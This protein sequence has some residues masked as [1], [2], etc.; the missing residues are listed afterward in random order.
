MQDGSVTPIGNF[1][2]N[3]QNRLKIRTSQRFVSLALAFI[4]SVN[5]LSAPLSVFIGNNVFAIDFGQK[6][7]DK[8]RELAWPESDKS[9]SA[10]PTD[11][12][13][14]AANASG[15]TPSNDC[16]AFVKT[17]IIAS[18]AD[19]GYP[20]AANE[21]ESDLVEYMGSSTKWTQVNTTNESDL[22]PGDILVSADTSGQGRNHIFVYLG[23]GKVAAANLN[24][25]YGRIENLADEWW[26]GNVPFYYGGNQYKV[27]RINS[28]DDSSSSS[29]GAKKSQISASQLEEF[30]QNNILFY[31]PSESDCVESTGNGN[32]DGSDVYMIGDSITVLSESYIKEKLPKITIN[33]QS[34]IWFA[35]NQTGLVSGVDRIKDMG[36]QKILV[37]AL[38]TNGGVT[39][40][41]INKLLDATKDKDLKIIL[42]TIYYANGLAEQQMNSTNEVVKKAADEYDNISYMDW[43]TIAS[44]DPG[45]YMTSDNIHP[46]A[47]GSEKFAEMVRDAV[48]K[49]T[50]IRA[51]AS[52]GGI[53]SGDVDYSAVYTAKNADKSVFAVDDYSEWSAMW[54]DGNKDDMKKLLENYGDLSY[55]L[56]EAINVPW[57]AII[58]QMKYED[59]NSVCG[60]NNFWGNGCDSSHA[61]KGGATVQGKNLG[62]GFAQYGQTLASDWYE[63]IRGITDPKKYLETLGPLWV[64]GDPNGAGYSTIEGMKKSID[65]LQEYIDSPEGQAI[66]TQFGNYHGGS[67]ICCNPSS[68]GIKWEDGWLAEG[69]IPG[70][71]RE[72]VTGRDD[73]REPVNPVGSYITSD[74]KPNKI[75]LHSTE[76]NT[77]GFAAYGDNKYPAHFTLDPRKKTVSQH[78]SIYQPALAIASHDKSGPIQIEIVG[79]SVPGS[80]GYSK[81]ADLHN[82]TDEDWDYLA[83]VLRAISEE[84]G[85]PLTS[86]VSWANGTERLSDKEFLEYKGVLGHMHVPDND[87]T[88]PGDIWDYVSKAIDRQGGGGSFCSTGGNGDLNATAIELAWPEHGH[89]P[90]NPTPA[91]AKALKEVGFSGWGDQC[92]ET[93]TSCDVF[94]TTVMRYSGADKDYECCVVSTLENYMLAHPEKYVEVENKLGVLEPGDIRISNGH[95]EMYVEINGQPYIA[96]ASNCDRTGEIGDFYEN[97]GTFR[98]YRFKK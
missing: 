72:D 64:Q 88:D 73:L 79:Y 78:F 14:R 26:N 42:T 63:P 38:G 97:S 48:N 55:Q 53:T 47:E 96:S 98:A 17:A 23:D 56:G 40:D 5:I 15:V 45:K 19:T 20:T 1:F 25:W 32:S 28:S 95:V 59:P 74:G 76:G 82:F 13:V 60:T 34:S 29:S 65:A 16:L 43:Y 6:I 24:E 57:I 3:R 54:S 31:D 21:Y 7:A 92:V 83:K 44:A 89:G 39:N 22:K 8:A 52:S 2:R 87:H 91:Y 68:T 9:K 66:V 27:F 90:F 33:A 80:P 30:A 37:F 41:D 71:I 11:A 58:V 84:T 36:N 70:L 94:V 4:F 51:G 62:E 35:E 86:S 75:L 18:G 46:T 69:S 85:I 77:N 10:S 50:N 93:G 81:E 49:V 12:F 67:G 61:Y